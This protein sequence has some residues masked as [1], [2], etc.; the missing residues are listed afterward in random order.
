MLEELNNYTLSVS[1][2]APWL[3]PLCFA[4][5]GA[6][7]GSFLNVVIYRLP[8][9][10]RVNEPARSFCPDCKKEIPW[11][12]NIPIISWLILRGKSACCKQR[13][14]ARYCVVE[15]ATALIFAAVAWQFSAE[16]LPV[17]VLLCIWMATMLAVLCIDWEQ[18]VVLPKLTNTAAAVGI[19]TALFAPWLVEPQALSATDG[20]LW[21]LCGAGGGYLLLKTVALMG[22]LL[23]GRKSKSYDRAQPWQLQQAGDDLELRIGNEVYLWSELF[24]ESS[25]RVT[26]RGADISA[27]KDAEPGDITFTVGTAVLADD[28]VIDLEEHDSLS[29]NCTGMSTSKEAMGSGDALIAISIGAV[30]GWQGVIFALVAGSC[31]GLLQALITR[32][33]RGE[34]M[35]FGPAFIIGAILYLFYGNVLINQYLSSF[36]Y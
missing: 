23:F 14:S 8:R 1:A 12:L 35:P 30:C 27:A 32:I 11:Y 34:P 36:A 22:R 13:I 4:M 5:F 31:V 28:S 16:S 15:T 29:G 10:M 18:M 25:N 20:L 17:Q 21:S 19:L 24:M 7:I 6:C 26:L 2:E 33:G 3:L 9:G